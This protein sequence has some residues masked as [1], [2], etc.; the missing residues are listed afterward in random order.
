[1]TRGGPN[2]A[3]LVYN[4]RFFS[5]TFGKLKMGYG[6]AM[7]YVLFLIMFVIAIVQLRLTRDMASSAF[8]LS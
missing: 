6:S 5:E 1:M 2:D 8:Q 3:T 4:F 7:S